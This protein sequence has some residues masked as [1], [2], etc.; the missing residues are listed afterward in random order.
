MDFVLDLPK[1]KK[2][3]NAVWVIVDR[4]TKSAHFFS[5]KMTFTLD[6]LAKIYVDEIISRYGVFI[7]I[8]FDRD[9]RFTLRF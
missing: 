4:L 8:V 6:R 9:P 7:F 5:I 3:N 1:I 2:G